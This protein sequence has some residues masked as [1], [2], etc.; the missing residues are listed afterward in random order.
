MV[1]VAVET[2]VLPGMCVPSGR[3]R[4]SGGVLRC[5]PLATGGQRRSVSSVQKVRKVCQRGL[6]PCREVMRDPGRTD[7]GIEIRQ[8]AEPRKVGRVLDAKLLVHL[9]L[10][11]SVGARVAQQLVWRETDASA[12]LDELAHRH[13]DDNAQIVMAIV[14]LLVSLPATISRPVG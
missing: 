9:G 2:T 5:S 11:A 13:T 12:R 4:P 10:Q 6:S 14:L 1:Y 8:L 3:S 7:D